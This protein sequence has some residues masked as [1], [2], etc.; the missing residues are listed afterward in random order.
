MFATLALS[1]VAL[2]ETIVFVLLLMSLISLSKGKDKVSE[3]Y[4][5]RAIVLAIMLFTFFTIGDQAFGDRANLLE[6]SI[7]AIS[8]LVSWVV[9]KYNSLSEEKTIKLSFS[10]DVKIALF[11]G[12]IL[13]II[14]SYS[15]FDFSKRTFPNKI[16]AVEGKEVVDNVYKFDFPFLADK[17]TMENT[18][19]TF[20]KEHPELKINYIYTSPDELHTKKKTHFLLYVFTEN[21]NDIK[22]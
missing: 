11:S 5:Y 1:F 4:F 19:K 12:L 22:N 3:K 13:I 21:K 18:I 20:K 10:K 2:I 8:L 16:K 17:I 14:T 9:F 7:F 6:H 15:I